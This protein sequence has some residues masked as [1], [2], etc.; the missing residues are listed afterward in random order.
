MSSFNL[1]PG[2]KPVIR[3]A[4][5]M[6][7][8]GGGGNLGYMQ[9][10]NDEKEKKNKFISDESIFGKKDETDLFVG[11]KEIEIPDEYKFNLKNLLIKFIRYFK[12]IL[13]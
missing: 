3:E 1:I 13:K 6:N 11:E 8:D 4:A 9:R 10:G 5:S 2:I 7:N 12:Q